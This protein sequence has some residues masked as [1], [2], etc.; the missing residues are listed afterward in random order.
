MQKVTI[1]I[2]RNKQKLRIIRS[3]DLL[4]KQIEE[5]LRKE[6][7]ERLRNLIIPEPE[8]NEVEIQHKPKRPQY[9]EYFTISNYNQPIQISFKNIPPESI[10]VSEAKI[11]I[12][13]AYD[14]GYND[15]KETTDLEYKAEILKYE[16]WIRKI[17]SVALEIKD[18]FFQEIK[19]FE[20]IIVSTSVMIAS[21]IL[22]REIS[23]DSEII[24]EQVKSAIATLEDEVILSIHLHPEDIEIIEQAKSVLTDEKKK[25]ENVKIVPNQIVER[26]GCILK[27]NAGNID[28][29]IA[30]QLTNISS[31][32]RKSI[33]DDREIAE[34][35]FFENATELNEQSMKMDSQIIASEEYLEKDAN[36][37]SEE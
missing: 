9:T 35:Q 28:A 19:L 24:I 15:G 33:A 30:T 17:D 18:K 26:G 10:T 21:E 23:K 2:P 5:R 7:E 27:S 13:R 8:P 4:N 3:Q 36:I 37:E 20:D 31:L 14:E 32:L 1:K 34:Q 29:R 22:K 6:E 16:D 12:Q 11:E 25:L